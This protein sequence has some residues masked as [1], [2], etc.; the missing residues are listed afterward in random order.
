VIEKIKNIFTDKDFEEILTKG[1]SF[2]LFRFGGLIVGFIF[3]Y[4]IAVNFGASVNGLIALSFT[5]LL[6]ISVIGRLGI[7]V[8]LIRF[9]SLPKNDSDK[10]LFYKVLLLAVLFSSTF[11]ILLYI[12]KDVFIYK[13]FNKPQLDPYIF[14]I[15]ITI[16]LWSMVLVCGGLF[17]A[18]KKNIWFVFLNNSGRFLFA[19]IVFVIL[20]LTSKDS[21]NPIKAHFY[22]VLLLAIIG[23]TQSI[24]LL[25][26]VTIKSGTNQ[27]SFLKESIP[28][29]V[30]G[31]I[32]VFLGWADT[33]VLGI[34]ET[35]AAVGVYNV[36]IKIATLTVFSFNALNSILAPKIAKN[37]HDKDEKNYK[38]MIRFTTT[39]N[40][41]IT[42]FIVIIIIWLRKYILGVFGEEF[43][44]GATILIILCAGQLIISLSGSVGII[45]QMTGHQRAYQYMVITALVLNIVLN[46]VLIPIYGATGAAIAT[47]ISISSWN[48][49]GVI[50]LKRKLN[51]ISHF[52]IKY[53]KD[54]L[55]NIK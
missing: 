18:K 17:R 20:L 42:L 32:I 7:E 21:L 15:V 25:N 23:I 36:A 44:S 10:G 39:L 9:F 37:F 26:G 53:W 40:S 41:F 2:L 48:I 38:K 30:S 55:Q 6:C 29:M 31:T 12:F 35:D 52:S 45:L 19:L 34:Y 3:T 50:Y 16:P 5:L 46:F 24:K 11:A 27:W 33:F 13:I 22:G 4:L 14:W 54:Y 8:N 49:L 43:L 28:M 1:F 47:V 51:I